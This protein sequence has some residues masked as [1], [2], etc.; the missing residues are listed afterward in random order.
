MAW[1]T[2]PRACLK[3]DLSP[4]SEMR[5]SIVHNVLLVG[6][7]GAG[8]TLLARAL[9]TILPKMYIYE[10]LDITRIYSAA[11]QLPPET[12]LMRLRPFRSPPG[13]ISTIPAQSIDDVVDIFQ[14]AIQQI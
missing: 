1:M 13:G 10:S 7:P 9:P 5:L 3:P 2:I 8:K 14:V 4:P 12:P 11:D 6:P